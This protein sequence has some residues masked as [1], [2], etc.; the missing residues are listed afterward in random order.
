MK[1]S[2]QVSLKEFS[3]GFLKYLERRRD[4]FA[5]GA[6]MSMSESLHG[7]ANMNEIIGYLLESLPENILAEQATKETEDFK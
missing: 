7:E 4:G 2:E 6:Q 5:S 3:A 1:D